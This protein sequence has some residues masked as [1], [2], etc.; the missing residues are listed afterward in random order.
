MR[1][2]LGL[3]LV[4]GLIVT[5]AVFVSGQPGLG[6]GAKAP[7]FVLPATQGG[8]RQ[9]FSLADSL[10]SGPV[11]I[12]FYPA[13]FTPG[14]TVEAHEFAQALDQFKAFGASVSGISAD[15]IDTLDKFSTSECQSKFPVASDHDLAVAKA[16]DAVLLK[17]TPKANRTSF[18][19]APDHTVLSVYSDLNPDHH[20]EKALA[21]LTA[22]Q[23]KSQAPNPS[24][25]PAPVAR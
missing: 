12:Y 20:V 21:A 10:K 11:V 6:P 17:V 13:A 16:Y 7:D 4:L 14:C 24:A 5:Q 2:V 23:T 25:A 8:H 18:V 1:L 9:S 3:L 22:W 19:I 15:D